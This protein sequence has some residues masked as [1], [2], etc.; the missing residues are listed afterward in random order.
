MLSHSLPK[1]PIVVGRNRVRA[2]S[3]LLKN[4]EIKPEYWIL[5]DGFQ[6]YKI[7]RNFDLV[8]ADKKPF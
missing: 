4:T 8:I 5:D 6:H 1:C 7:K 2:A 3:W